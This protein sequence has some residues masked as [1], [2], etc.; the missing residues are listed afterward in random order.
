[1]AINDESPVAEV[2][3][4]VL[5]GSTFSHVLSWGA[6][7]PTLKPITGIS[8][9]APP[10]IT[11]PAHGLVANWPVWIAD[12]QGMKQ[13]N[14]PFGPDESPDNDPYTVAIIDSS[15]ISLQGQSS[16]S[17]TAYLSGGYLLYFPP[18]DLSGYTARMQI[19][20]PKASSTIIL[21]LNTSNGGIVLDNVGKTIT[22][23]MTAVQTA[24]LTFGVAD[25]DLEMISGSTVTRILQGKI[26]LST[27]VTR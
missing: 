15:N 10:V 14:N 5:Q 23:V 3:L 17:Y 20:Q 13:I 18:I 12:V 8:K 27:E 1:M 24:A 11:A 6:D 7:P 16:I 4:L 26:S 25:Y 19:R 2:N 22:L 21:E 9:A